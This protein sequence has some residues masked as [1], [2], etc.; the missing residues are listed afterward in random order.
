M[1]YN[2]FI[3]W[4]GERGKAAAQALRKWIPTV[5][6]SAKPWMSATDIEKGSRGLDEIA[7][8]L[9]GVR[10]GISCVTPESATAPW[11]LFEA[12]AL[13][14]SL[15]DKS[16][17]CTLLLGG[18]R[19]NDVLPPLGLFQATRVEKAEIRQLIG[20]VNRALG[21]DPVPDADLDEIF[22]ALWP[23]L[24]DKLRAA[25]SLSTQG[26]VKRE[27]YDM[28]S[29]ILDLSRVVARSRA[30]ADAFKSLIE[31]LMPLF[32]LLRAA[33]PAVLRGQTIVSA[34]IPSGEKWFEPGVTVGQGSQNKANK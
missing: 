32:N 23:N 11:L 15:D 31:D 3:S 9:E 33:A 10:V 29:E 22:D 25:E 1:A 24:E 14:K 20:S 34:A 17:L 18:L 19:P 6:Q 26:P 2:I 12:G 21:S 7:R 16:R 8:A 4:S 28:V 13:S 27:L 5:I 30:E